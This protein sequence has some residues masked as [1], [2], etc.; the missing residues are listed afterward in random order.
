MTGLLF[1]LEGDYTYPDL[2]ERFEVVAAPPADP[3]L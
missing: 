3:D 1:G 2:L